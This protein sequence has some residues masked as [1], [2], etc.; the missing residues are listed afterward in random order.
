MTEARESGLKLCETLEVLAEQQRRQ[1]FSD[2]DILI[3]T[4]NGNVEE[5]V[6]GVK[7]C[8]VGKARNFGES[9]NNY[10]ERSARGWQCK[11]NS[12]VLSFAS[13]C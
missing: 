5:I 3:L 11:D 7:R 9:L 1:N 6:A 4:K 13:M 8:A 10:L 12:S 2:K